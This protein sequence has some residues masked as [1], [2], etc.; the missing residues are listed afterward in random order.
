[1]ARLKREFFHVLPVFLFFLTAFFLINLNERFLLKKAGMTP[2]SFLELALAA[3]VVAKVFL[4][5]DHLS[6]IEVCKKKPLV[7][8]VLWKT[9]LYWMIL[10][11]VRVV[12][13]MAPYLLGREGLARDV[14]AFAEH[15]DWRF[16]VSIQGYYVL[17]L[18]LYV[19]FREMAQAIRAIA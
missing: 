14:A 9:L 17:L 15:F 7:Y 13:R 8:I 16:F 6:W 12:F 10:I 19:T 4:V 18:L 1:M 5:I 3:G 11:A 2:F